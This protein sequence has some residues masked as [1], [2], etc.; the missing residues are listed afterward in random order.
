MQNSIEKLNL[1]T[2]TTLYKCVEK[3][4]NI[5][6]AGKW[7]IGKT[8]LVKHEIKTIGEPI[9]QKP[10]RQPAHLENHI[11]EAIW[12]LEQHGI[13]KK[14]SSPWNTPMVCV[15]KKEKKEICLCLDFRLLNQITERPAFPMPNIDEMLDSLKGARWFSSVDLGNAY[16]QVELEENSR[17]KT[18]FSTKTGQFCFTRMPFGIAAAPAT[19]QKLMTDVLGEMLWKEALVYLDD[20]LIFSETEAQHLDRL[21]KLFSKIQAAGL[22]INPEKCKLF[23]TELKFLGHIVNRDGIKTDPEKIRAIQDFEKPNC[24]KK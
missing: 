4:K 5:F 22:R 12:N 9:L 1:K 6:M 7:D 17:L 11:D 2:N 21:D 18:A 8:K 10:R 3:Y 19:F 14:C 15:W 16:Y 23:Q 20:I 13:I 24:I